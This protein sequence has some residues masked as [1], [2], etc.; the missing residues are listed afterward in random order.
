VAD[1]QGPARVGDFAYPE[2][3]QPHPVGAAAQ[4]RKIA[5][6]RA[7]AGAT[8]VFA[9]AHGYGPRDDFARRATVA[10]Q[11]SGQRLWVNRYGYL[12]DAKLA[13][14]GTLPRSQIS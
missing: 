12:S 10:W 5:Q 6:M 13:V 8:P 1:D 3:D 2:P 4:A 7:A 9:L 14:L 11:A